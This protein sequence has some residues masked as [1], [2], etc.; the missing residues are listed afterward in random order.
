[1]NRT[2]S[3]FLFC[4]ILA[5]P[6]LAADPPPGARGEVI[7]VIAGTERVTIP[8]RMIGRYADAAAPGFDLFLV[9][10]EG[11][12][13]EEVG[14]ASGMSGSPVYF[15]GELLGA[16]SV[17]YGLLSKRAIGG[18]T[19]REDLYRAAIGG[20]PRPTQTNA[21][22][23]RPI[24]TP[25]Q[26][27]G[28]HPEIRS[29]LENELEARGYQPVAGSG[30]PIQVDDWKAEPGMPI[31]MALVRG[32]WLAGAT[33]TITAVEGD[34]IYAFGHPVLGVGDMAVPM[35]EASVVHTLADGFGSF[36]MT[37]IGRTVGTFEE[38]RLTAV[39]GRRSLK[40]HMLP[41]EMIVEGDG[42]EDRTFHFEVARELS[43]APLLAG[44]AVSQLITSHPG[45]EERQTIVG[46]LRI[47][48]ADGPSLTRSYASSG[49]RARRAVTLFALEL[50]RL[51]GTI[52]ADPGGT[53]D[54]QR[55]VLRLNVSKQRREY[56]LRRVLY[57]RRVWRPGEMLRLKVILDSWRGETKTLPVEIQLPQAIPA[58]GKW[59]LFVGAVPADS[60]SRAPEESLQTWRERVSGGRGSGGVLLRLDVGM[61]LP[62]TFRN[63]V[64]SVPQ[65]ERSQ[66]ESFTPLD[67]PLNGSET[68]EI[69]MVTGEDK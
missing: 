27:S 3:A 37:S 54:P 13:A 35:T 40:P 22:A 56:T 25:I 33:G 26:F 7:T 49:Q 66:F 16:L 1:V 65:T 43:I 58:Q 19:P 62:G 5:V 14:V 32:D 44:A 2:L 18:V 9:E 53:P 45:F 36:R 67:G 60:L 46:D 29:W 48:W 17:R 21:A 69:R 50:Q 6:L 30:G 39:V 15:D 20:R 51:L 31:G 59:K 23:A 4:L 11:P 68:I 41:V 55:V 24:A 12:I 47:D 63:L 61:S 38:D 34:R 64:G 42:Y 52:W 8:V 28:T 10:L 57:E